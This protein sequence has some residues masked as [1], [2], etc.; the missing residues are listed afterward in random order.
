MFGL[1]LLDSH[2]YFSEHSELGVEEG[3]LP[4]GH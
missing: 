3:E 4:I 1:H 2:I